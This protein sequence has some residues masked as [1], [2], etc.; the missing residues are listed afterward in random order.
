MKRA[1]NDYVI[2]THL[3]WWKKRNKQLHLFV[4]RLLFLLLVWCSNIVFFSLRQLK[5]SKKARFI[6][7]LHAPRSIA[8]RRALRNIAICK[9]LRQFTWT[10]LKSGF[11]HDINSL[12]CLCFFSGGWQTVSK[13][14]WYQ[15]KINFIRCVDC[16]K[17]I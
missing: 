12:V 17:I 14:V 15:K 5:N 10:L 2:S 3:L 13:S 16:A 6:V 9:I 4:Y 7:S 1:V 8:K 11:W